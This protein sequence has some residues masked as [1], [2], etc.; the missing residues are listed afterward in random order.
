MS[1]TAGFARNGDTVLWLMPEWVFWL[2]L[3]LLAVRV[4]NS[5]RSAVRTWKTEKARAKFKY[6]P[7]VTP[8]TM[9]AAQEAQFHLMEASRVLERLPSTWNTTQLKHVVSEA[10]DYLTKARAAL[11]RNAPAPA[12]S[13]PP[14]PSPAYE[15]RTGLDGLPRD[16]TYWEITGHDPHH[17]PPGMKWVLVDDHPTDA[18]RVKTQTEGTELDVQSSQ[19]STN[20]K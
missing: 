13:T 7:S 3:V 18:R 5:L 17:T 4:V 8:T 20:R 16:P 14:R 9:P 12:P 19:R 10:E 11:K 1:M 6:D 2:V 15:A